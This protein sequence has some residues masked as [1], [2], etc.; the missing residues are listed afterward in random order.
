[1]QRLKKI[2]VHVHSTPEVFLTKP[3]G[4]IYATP[5]EL[6]YIYDT[7]NVEKGIL[8]PSTHPESSIDLISVREAYSMVHDYPE[9]L[10]WWFCNPSPLMYQNSPDTD[11]SF[12]INQ[13]KE[14]GA[15]G[16]GEVT[17]NR[18]FNDPY[19]ENLFYHAEKCKMPV[20]IHIGNSGG[21][22]YGLIDGIGLPGLERTLEKFPD[23][24][25]LGHSQK[26]WAEISG[27]LTEEQR[28]GYPTGKVKPG[29]RVVE[30]MRKYPNLYGDLSAGSGYNAVSRDPDFGY[31][32]LE[33][34]Q[35][36]LFFG[37]DICDP[38]NITR[39]MLKLSSFLDEAME[40][41]K[42]SYSAYEKISR[43]NALRLLGE[44]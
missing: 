14:K 41:E 21:G 31:S 39:P 35:D 27:D 15:K 34:F 30:L 19:V 7:C 26:F 16:I 40:N 20:T 8:L 22:D 25:I 38:R 9:T 6:R 32:F 13:L 5:P 1:M 43:N 37:T 2:D 17:L 11:L 4:G 33:E 18:P 23:L 44:I 10:G 3:D 42:I 29:G 12:F 28:S 24:I 36:R